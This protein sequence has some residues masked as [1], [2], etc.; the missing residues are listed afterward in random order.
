MIVA[1]LVKA[2][3]TISA[4]PALS[5]T[6]CER[7]EGRARAGHGGCSK[8]DG[9]G[10]ACN[11]YYKEDV[12]NGHRLLPCSYSSGRCEALYNEGSELCTIEAISNRSRVALEMLRRSSQNR[13]AD[14]WTER[15]AITIGDIFL[16]AIGVDAATPL[17]TRV[18]I[19]QT[20]LGGPNAAPA[21]STATSV[22]AHADKLSCSM[23]GWVDSPH[24]VAEVAESM[25]LDEAIGLETL[26]AEMVDAVQRHDAE[27]LLASPP[28]PPPPSSIAVGVSGDGCNLL[29]GT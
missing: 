14:S 3:A 8:H 2:S 19:I 5:R 10:A 12:G 25:P 21:W 23:W 29:D 9:S 27:P 24:T 11:S 18:R 15:L 20:V 28:P 22:R 1:L 13:T 7:F 6:P 17:A 4:S 26:L 16:P